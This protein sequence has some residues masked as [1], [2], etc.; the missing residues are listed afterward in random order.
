MSRGI[1]K[2]QRRLLAMIEQHDPPMAR[3]RQLVTAILVADHGVDLQACAKHI[4]PLDRS[5]RRALR[6]LEQR[7]LVVEVEQRPV[8]YATPAWAAEMAD[9]GEQFGAT[10][11][12][13][14]AHAMPGSDGSP[15]DGGPPTWNL[16][17]PERWE[18]EAPPTEPA[19]SGPGGTSA[20]ATPRS[21]IG[22]GT[23]PPWLVPLLGDRLLSPAE[24]GMM[25]VRAAAEAYRRDGDDE[26]ADAILKAIAPK[27][28]RGR[29][30]EWT[31]EQVLNLA[32]DVAEV[33][34]ANPSLKGTRAIALVAKR[35]QWRG[36][37]ERA[38]RDHFT[39]RFAA[40]NSLTFKQA[41]ETLR[42][43]ALKI[44]RG[45]SQSAE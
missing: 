37:G 13:A 15:A 23:M 19:P 28:G 43:H 18:Q 16:F 21:G 8:A 41:V 32:V 27:R 26:T 6:L 4:R 35:P 31:D 10:D 36:L 25:H 9:A 24:E 14:G 20:T 17:A 3:A 42:E 7:N 38:L 45:S 33:L 1:G 11:M 34:C 22:L 30:P 5:V 40:Y 12:R 44:V 39:R 29:P 2:L